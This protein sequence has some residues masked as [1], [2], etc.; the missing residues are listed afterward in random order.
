MKIS[1]VTYS[2]LWR[3][4]LEFSAWMRRDAIVG[5]VSVPRSGNIPAEMIG[6]HLNL[7][8]VTLPEFC[9]HG[10]TRHEGGERFN[11]AR[12]TEG[13]V[14]LLDDSIH[15]G[16]AMRRAIQAFEARKCRGSWAYVPAAIYGSDYCE[17]YKVL[18]HQ[19]IPKPRYFAWNLF[20]HRELATTAFDFDGVLCYDPPYSPGEDAA[21]LASL[22]QACPFYLPSV[23]IRNIVTG[24]L[25]ARRAVS[26]RWLARN[27]V[28]LLD[29]MH[30][31]PFADP[32]ERRKY[33]A[34]RWKGETYR[35]LPCHLFIESHDDSAAVIARTSGKPVI[36][37]QSGAV[38]QH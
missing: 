18:T 20:G 4:C 22:D 2:Q 35:D 21:Y 28:R 12:P 7:P 14:V 8:V 11:C 17:H 25:E 37:M 24:R 9:E 36:S 38:F 1:Y 29:R 3:D 10:F 15:S 31:A 23:P 27:G 34:A 30:M 6:L 16:S 26:E 32:D 33:G 19:T 13:V 5:I